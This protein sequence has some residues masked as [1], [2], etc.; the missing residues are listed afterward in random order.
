MRPIS[1]RKGDRLS[2]SS[3]AFAASIT[4]RPASRIS[5]CSAVI[6]LEMVTGVRASSRNAHTSTAALTANTRQYS[7]RIEPN[8]G[9]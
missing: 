5:S 6:L 7:P 1:S 2:R 9:R 4:T 3:A 8:R